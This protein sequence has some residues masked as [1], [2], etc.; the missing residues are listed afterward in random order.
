MT[1]MRRTITRILWWTGLACQLPTAW[2]WIDDRLV[3]NLFSGLPL[4]CDLTQ[5][6]CDTMPGIWRLLLSAIIGYAAWFAVAALHVCPTSPETAQTKAHPLPM[7]IV[8]TVV[9]IGMPIVTLP[10]AGVMALTAM[11]DLGW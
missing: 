11:I 2:C 7:R 10:V 6:D 9:T 5:P 8:V 3:A 1:G 4:S